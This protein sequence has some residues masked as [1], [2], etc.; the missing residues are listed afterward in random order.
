MNLIEFFNLW[1]L[2]MRK[3]TKMYFLLSILFMAF[4]MDFLDFFQ[5]LPCCE[6]FPLDTGSRIDDTPEALKQFLHQIEIVPEEE[7]VEKLTQ[8]KIAA[9]RGKVKNDFL[10]FTIKFQTIV[11]H[12]D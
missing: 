1:M 7:K 9:L 2:N 5:P 12:E 11:K 8:K 10:Y 4:K 6:T 3:S